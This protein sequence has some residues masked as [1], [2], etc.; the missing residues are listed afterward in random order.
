MSYI[1]CLLCIIV[2]WMDSL[3]SGKT[4]IMAYGKLILL[5]AHN[6]SMRD[7]LYCDCYEAKQLVKEKSFIKLV[8][9]K[10]VIL[11]SVS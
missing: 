2:F 11:A 6:D 3:I 9:Y 7:T 1:K 8:K 10:E 4:F 5:L